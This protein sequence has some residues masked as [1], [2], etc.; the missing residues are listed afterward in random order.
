MYDFSGNKSSLDDC[1]PN[2]LFEAL[3]SVPWKQSRIIFWTFFLK[4]SLAV[5]ADGIGPSTL[6]LL[7]RPPFLFVSGV[8][9]EPTTLAL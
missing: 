8:G 7:A 6:A 5:A 4:K 3:P 1:F 9:F 2:F